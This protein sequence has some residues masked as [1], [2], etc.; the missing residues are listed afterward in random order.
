MRIALFVAGQ[1]GAGAARKLVEDWVLGKLRVEIVA[2]VAPFT[3]GEPELMARLNDIPFIY[4]PGPDHL[5]TSHDYAWVV[6]EYDVDLIISW[7]WVGEFKGV[8][9]P[10][11]E[12]RPARLPE[13]PGENYG[14]RTQSWVLRDYNAGFIEETAVTFHFIGGPVAQ[15]FL[16]PIKR[17]INLSTGE[18]TGDSIGLVVEDLALQ[19]ATTVINNVAEGWIGL[20]GTRRCNLDRPRWRIGSNV[21]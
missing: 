5:R 11:L 16:L 19:V 7:G 4:L 17:A 18:I 6:S 14:L 10:V 8:T 12:I 20:D 3:Q 1:R 13:Y 21:K 2:I 9:L 15:A